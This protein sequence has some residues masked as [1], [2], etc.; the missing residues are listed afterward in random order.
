[1]NGEIETI[2]TR[3]SRQRETGQSAHRLEAARACWNS[4]PGSTVVGLTG[5]ARLTT[6]TASARSAWEVQARI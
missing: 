1:M 4:R 3:K 5:G 6:V 2:T